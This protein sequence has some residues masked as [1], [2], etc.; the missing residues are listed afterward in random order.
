MGNK[1]SLPNETMLIAGLHKVLEHSTLETKIN[2]YKVIIEAIFTYGAKNWLL[3]SRTN[4]SSKV[5]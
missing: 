2:I 4:E 1:I 3:T 5:Y